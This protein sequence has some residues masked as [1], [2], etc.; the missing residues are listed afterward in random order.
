MHMMQSKAARRKQ[1]KRCHHQRQQQSQPAP[2][3]IISDV[4]CPT[5]TGAIRGPCLALH[6]AAVCNMHQLRP[7]ATRG[8]QVSKDLH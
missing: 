2:A 6:S 5:S 1:R 7:H 8:R 3:Q 4:D